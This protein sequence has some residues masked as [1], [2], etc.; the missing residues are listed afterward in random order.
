MLGKRLGIGGAG[1]AFP[2]LNTF[3]AAMFWLVLFYFSFLFY[4]Y[5]GSDFFLGSLARLSKP[6]AAP[7]VSTWIWRVA[8][9]CDILLRTVVAGFVL[10]T[11]GPDVHVLVHVRRLGF[12]AAPVAHQSS[13]GEVSLSC[14]VRMAYKCGKL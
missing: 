12:P 8:S 4:L 1:G 3:S 11:Y 13:P 14:R 5:S 2:K 7:C 10:A 6:A 9:T